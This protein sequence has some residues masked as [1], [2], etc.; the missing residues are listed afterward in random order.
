MEL[1]LT[2]IAKRMTYTIGRR[3]NKAPLE[4][5]TLNHLLNSF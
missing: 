4:I 2:R 5:Y 1:V 3:L